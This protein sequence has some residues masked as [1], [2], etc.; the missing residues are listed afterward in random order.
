MSD[1]THRGAADRRMSDQP[2]YL[3]YDSADGVI[4]AIH[5][6]WP[7]YPCPPGGGHALFDLAQFPQGVVF[8][9]VSDIDR[10][11]LLEARGYGEN[12][13]QARDRYYVAAWHED[14]IALAGDGLISGVRAATEREWEANRRDLMRKKLA[15]EGWT[16]SGD[17]LNSLYF[18][19]GNE[20]VPVP[21]DSLEEYAHENEDDWLPPVRSYAV[22]GDEGITVTER[23]WRQVEKSL[24]Q[25]SVELPPDLSY[26][27]D[28]LRLNLYD[29]AVR[30]IALALECR[31]RDALGGSAYGQRLAEDFVK[32]LL[33]SSEQPTSLSKIYRLRLRTFFKFVRNVFAH[34]RVEM[35]RPQALAMITHVSGILDDINALIGQENSRPS[36]PQDGPS[37]PH[38]EG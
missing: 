33:A 31:L 16:G 14:L 11:L 15:E 35:T 2:G 34:N 3:N 24:S 37:A 27:D 32:N 19:R 36:A 29:T 17:P 18:K 21:W 25:V 4:L 13:P 8:H 5:T 30:E 26:I 9:Q 7:V 1:A 12:N 28:L 23:G 10:C 22:V 6:D 38:Q 20:F